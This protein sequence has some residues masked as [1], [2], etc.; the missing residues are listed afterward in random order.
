[1]KKK[2]IEL[3]KSNEFQISNLKD[4][5]KQKLDEIINFITG[6]EYYYIKYLNDNTNIYPSIGN[7]STKHVTNPID[8]LSKEDF[9][10]LKFETIIEKQQK[11]SDSA[12]YIKEMNNVI[13]L[14]G[15]PKDYLN[16]Y[17]DKFELIYSKRKYEKKHKEKIAT[18]QNS[19]YVKNININIPQN[20]METNES[21]KNSE[22]EKKNLIQVIDS[23]TQSLMLYTMNINNKNL[24]IS[25]FVDFKLSCTGC[26]EKIL[27]NKIEYIVIGEKGIYHFDD[28]PSKLMKNEE[29]LEKYKKDKRNYKGNIKIDDN[30][31]AFTSNSVL[32]GG[33]DIIV[34]YD[35][36]KKTIINSKENYSFV[37]S[38]NGLSI[39]DLEKENKKVLLCACKKYTENQTNGI[40]LI[41]T[42]I[43]EKKKLTTIYVDTDSFEVNCFCQINIEENNKMI[44]TNYFFVG[45]FDP[46]ER[47]GIIKLCK[48]TYINNEFNIEIL[49]DIVIDYTEEFNGFEGAVNIIIQS[50]INR[51]IL[52]SCWDG[53]VYCFS[54]PNIKL[55]LEE[56][57]QQDRIFEV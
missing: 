39:M 36:N 38:V 7:P 37:H 1:M 10:I 55:Y 51:K 34:F 18:N 40:L 49:E 3:L 11:V 35:M 47:K 8:E 52:V 12:K 57:E 20:I 14:I 29:N 54:E 48:L 42:E 9:E 32:N 15:G 23:S 33:E 26:Y 45:G 4:D 44:K 43:E 5:L 17:N 27:N 24:K 53:N 19:N 6:S 50:K 25:S 16:I 41:D 46:K 22:H 2:V 13:F 56:D 31:L 21:I 30:I 28:F